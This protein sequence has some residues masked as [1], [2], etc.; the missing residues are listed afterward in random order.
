[1][2][3]RQGAMLTCSALAV[4]LFAGNAAAQQRTDTTRLTAMLS[5]AAEASSPGSR[6]GRGN[7]SITLDPAKGEVC[8]SIE[9]SGLQHVTA[10]HIHQG[11]V[12]NSGPAVIPLTAPKNG[13]SNGCATVKRSLIDQMAKD[14]NDF[15]VN[16]HDQEYPDG[17]I[18]GQL[19][20]V[21]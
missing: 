10:A 13:T 6:N 21:M 16:V 5:G 4:L 9:V 2:W 3:S 17:A 7:A 14:P 1:M 20:R 18:R 11:S 8:Y 15:Y 19:Q 12:G